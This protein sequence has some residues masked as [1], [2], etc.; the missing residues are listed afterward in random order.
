MWSGGCGRASSAAMVGT[1]SS[2]TVQHRQPLVSST[3]ASSGTVGIGAVF[4]D[5]A[6]D[7]EIAEFV[8]QDRQ[9]AALRVP[10]SGGEPAWSFRRRGNR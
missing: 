7:A 8:D 3:M 6:V 5:V 1:K 4:Q 2:A 10:P 9:P